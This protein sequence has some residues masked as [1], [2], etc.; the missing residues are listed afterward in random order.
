MNVPLWFC[1]RSQPRRERIAASQLA[2]LEGLEVFLPQV[3]FPR[4][5]AKGKRRVGEPLFPSYLFARFD[6]A[7]SQK[8]VSYAHGVHYIVSTGGKAKVVDNT[9]IG[10][11]KALTVNDV[12]EVTPEP[13]VVGENVRIIR[14]IFAQSE[15]VIHSLKPADQRVVVLLELLGGPQTVELAMDDLETRFN[16][17]V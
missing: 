10:E 7:Q 16:F 2:Q 14:G 12:I 4:P 17:P 6:P 15:G 8:A 13:L 1:I 5:T 11:L 3:R 9:V